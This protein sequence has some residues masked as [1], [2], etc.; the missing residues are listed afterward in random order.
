MAEPVPVTELSVFSS[1]DA[2]PT[3][4]QQARDELAAAELY[5]F[6]TV[7]PDGLGRSA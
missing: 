5:W 3:E 2:R 7:R 4:W 6:P 1:P